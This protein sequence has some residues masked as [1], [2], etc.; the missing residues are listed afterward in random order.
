MKY[1]S[2]FV[3]DTVR[4]KA[5]VPSYESEDADTWLMLKEGYQSILSRRPK[6]VFCM[7]IFS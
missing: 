7:E 5:L 4:P 3:A 2:F 1:L 6:S